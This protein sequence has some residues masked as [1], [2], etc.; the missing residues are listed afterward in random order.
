MSTLV[1][2][3]KT[4]SDILELAKTNVVVE[5]IRPTKNPEISQ[6]TLMQIKERGGNE[7]T[8]LLL[9]GSQETIARAWRPVRNEQIKLLGIEE[10]KAFPKVG[11]KKMVLVT[12]EIVEG[13]KL[14]DKSTFSVQKWITEDGEEKETSPK[15]TP[16]QKFKFQTLK[17]ENIYR[18]QVP[19]LINENEKA[20]EDILL[21]G[22]KIPVVNE[23]RIFETVELDD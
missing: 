12:Q 18:V 5:E 11:G 3:K 20:P 1:N 13:G 21:D 10:G 16:D 17:G 22:V 7:V 9:G 2:Q 23:S 8:N 14:I 15:L 6:L 19:M 4:Q